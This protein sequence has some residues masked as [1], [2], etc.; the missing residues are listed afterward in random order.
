MINYNYAFMTDIGLERKRN[1]DIAYAKT[2]SFGE[3][4]LIVLDGMGGHRKGDIASKKAFNS[5]LNDFDIRSKPFNSVL[6]AKM[7]LT[8]AIKSANKELYAYGSLNLKNGEVLGTT[9]VVVIYFKGK[10]IVGS[11]GDSRCYILNES[12]FKQVT[13]DD[14]ERYVLLKKKKITLQ[15]YYSY[16]GK[17]KLT[18]ALG[19]KSSIKPKVKQIKEK[20]NKLLLCSDGLYSKM[21]NLEM[22]HLLLKKIDIKFRLKELVD[23]ALERGG[24]DNIG[25]VI[26][27]VRR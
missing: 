21:S 23:F 6:G 3:S 5:I 11:V 12:G 16:A 17:N 13:E 18:K 19:V 20:Y 14:S 2:N 10:T 25:L 4:I 9:V 27:E 1:E 15:E 22:K 26:F 7:W 24:E 8:Y